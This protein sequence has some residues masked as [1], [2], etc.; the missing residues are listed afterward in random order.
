M[1]KNISRSKTFSNRT[2]N[3]M[4]DLFKFLWWKLINHPQQ[5]NTK[6]ARIVSNRDIDQYFE[7]SSKSCSYTKTNITKYTKMVWRISC[8][9]LKLLYLLICCFNFIFLTFIVFIVQLKNSFIYVKD[10]FNFY[11]RICYYLIRCL[12][13][14]HFWSHCLNDLINFWSSW[15]AAYHFQEQKL[16]IS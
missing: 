14:V 9:L 16:L 2:S 13:V 1:N 3:C 11:R 15:D 12:W 4:K 5:L 6:D 8:H 7:L 10:W